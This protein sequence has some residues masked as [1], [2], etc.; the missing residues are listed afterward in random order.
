[1]K[2]VVLLV[3]SMCLF[4]VACEAEELDVEEQATDK[5]CSINSAGELVC[6]DPDENEES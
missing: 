2:K 3:F 1:M 5:I 6:V 4:M